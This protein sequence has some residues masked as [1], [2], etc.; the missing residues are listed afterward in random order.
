MP[1]LVRSFLLVNVI[2]VFCVS[3]FSFKSKEPCVFYKNEFNPRLISD[4]GVFV[5]LGIVGCVYVYFVGGDLVG[6]GGELTEDGLVLIFYQFS[7]L[8]IGVLLFWLA[9]KGLNSRLVLL[10]LFLLFVC[11]H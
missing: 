8:I 11:S 6:S 5:G 4:F 2:V 7:D 9:A 10:A 1:E 3:V